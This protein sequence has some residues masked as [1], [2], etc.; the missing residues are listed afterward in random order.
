M[1]RFPERTMR[2][3]LLVIGAVMIVSAATAADAA[4]LL[5][6][7]NG[8][9]AI[10]CGTKT[11]PCRSISAAVAN[12]APG[13]T[14][15]VGPGLYGDVNDN[16]T[17]DDPGDESAEV[18][19]G[20]DCLI[21][22]H[23]PVTI[24]SA[25]G[26]GVTIIS[27][28]GASIGAVRIDVD[29]VRFGKRNHGFTLTGALSDGLDATAD[30][31]AIEGNLATGNGQNGFTIVGNGNT[32]VGNEASANGPRGFSVTGER[33][34]ITDNRAN[35]HTS[36]GF[37]IDNGSGHLIA[38]NVAAGNL[39]RGF[40]LDSATEYLLADNLAVRNGQRGF[41]FDSAD[42]LTFTGAAAIGNGQVGFAGSGQNHR[43]TSAVAVGNGTGISMNASG[44]VITKS[45]LFGSTSDCGL[46]NQSDGMLDAPGN[47]WGS[48][49]GPGSD[50]ADDACEGGAGSTTVDPVATK[51]F[52]IKNKAAQ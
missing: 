34:I 21:H 47:F 14:I 35:G 18:D 48:A 23:K 13:A 12:A 20:C 9:D 46:V 38:R 19:A 27:A 44:A 24:I 4:K 26:K 8:T 39:Q 33:C 37:S 36:R 5:V 10:G 3:A 11:A 42:A 6:A 16:G 22:V 32:I 43:I 40:S 52:K 51:E 28:G 25:R 31:V 50:P 41:S 30:R 45:N 2:R 29:G 49:G 1:R 15:E 17:F 7:N